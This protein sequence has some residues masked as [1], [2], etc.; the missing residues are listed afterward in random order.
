MLNDAG[1]A[2]NANNG[3]VATGNKNK[4]PIT[5]AVER[6]VVRIKNWAYLNVGLSQVF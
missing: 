2:N 6:V 4:K 1:N 5:M 3:Y